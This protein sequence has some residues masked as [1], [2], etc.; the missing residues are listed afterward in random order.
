MEANISSLAVECEYIC[1]KKISIDKHQFLIEAEYMF[2][3]YVKPLTTVWPHMNCHIRISGDIEQII[4][5]IIRGSAPPIQF[6]Q[7]GRT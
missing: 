3:R 6:R 2:R 4:P 1:N 7:N 5:I